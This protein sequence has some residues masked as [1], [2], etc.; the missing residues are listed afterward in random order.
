MELK[1]YNPQEDGF[2]QNMVRIMVGTL[3]RISEGKLAPHAIPQVLAKRDRA[4][5]GITAPACGL[6]LDYVF[7]DWDFR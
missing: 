6:Y 7:Y 1:I 2:L 3:L 5:A 4:A